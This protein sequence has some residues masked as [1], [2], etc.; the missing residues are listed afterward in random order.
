MQ[1]RERARSTTRQGTQE[2]RIQPLE[3]LLLLCQENSHFTKHITISVYNPTEPKE[4]LPTPTVER[5]RDR[6][7]GIRSPGADDP[8]ERY[9]SLSLSATVGKIG[10]EI[11]SLFRPVYINISLSLCHFFTFMQRGTRRWHTWWGQFSTAKPMWPIK[12]FPFAYYMG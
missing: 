7:N 12:Y 8:R 1:Q 3:Y 11:F 10:V 2:K 4:M 5:D 9:F 6:R